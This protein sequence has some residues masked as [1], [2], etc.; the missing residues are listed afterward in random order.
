MS[1]A[2][3]SIVLI[4]IFGPVSLWLGR[5][6]YFALKSGIF[7]ARQVP[8]GNNPRNTVHRDERP[9]EYWF[10]IALGT[11]AFGTAAL[12]ALIGLFFLIV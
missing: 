9:M 3:R 6:L 12:M 1:A 4:A 7:K 8:Y 5:D 10:A 2:A 11:V